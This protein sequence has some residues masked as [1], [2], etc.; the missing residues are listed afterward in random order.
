MGALGMALVAAGLI[1]AGGGIG[2]WLG[3]LDRAVGEAKLEETRAELDE[4]RRE[5][6]EHFGQTAGHFQA[7]GQQYKA[8]YEHLADGSQ[9]LCDTEALDKELLFPLAGEAALEQAAGDDPGETLDSTS[10][11]TSAE[12]H[13]PARDDALEAA[14]VESETDEA[15][16]TDVAEAA[17]DVGADDNDVSAEPRQSE[18][19]ADE[20][21]SAAGATD[22]AEEPADNVVELVPRSESSGDDPDSGGD[23]DDKRTYH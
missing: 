21:I 15:V 19:A 4:Y 12:E 20:D 5:V 23:K 8:L 7:L 22:T 13:S 6:T 9:K 10:S 18:S 3:R 1:L 16:E 14:A 17:M 2:F 11:D